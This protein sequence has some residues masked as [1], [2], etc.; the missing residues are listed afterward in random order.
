EAYMQGL[1]DCQQ[2]DEFFYRLFVSGATEKVP[3]SFSLLIDVLRAK[4]LNLQSRS[5][6]FE[7]GEKHYDLGNA[8]Y[9]KM[10]GPSMVYSCGYW[11]NAKNV[12]EAQ[13][14]KLDLICKKLNLQ[15]GQ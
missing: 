7:V 2:L 14:N 4:F 15:K 11:L 12:D 5:R 3:A 13:F 8:F 10:L 9:E 1:W 6:A